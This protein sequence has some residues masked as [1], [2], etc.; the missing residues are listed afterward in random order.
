[1]QDAE[2]RRAIYELTIRTGSTPSAAEV[3]NE[4]DAAESD[5]AAAFQRLA[6]GRILFLENGK[7][8]MAAPF[9]G[10]PTPYVVRTNDKSYYANCIW[11]ALGISPMLKVDSD[12]FTSCPDC[13]EPLELS[14]RG[15][16]L[17]GEGIVHFSVPVRQWWEDLV[18]T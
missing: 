6:E 12:I 1:M 4:I 15:G 8:R 7:I 16:R 2:V 3:A 9:S 13:S 11:D 14:V 17:R 5:V 18:F 10:V